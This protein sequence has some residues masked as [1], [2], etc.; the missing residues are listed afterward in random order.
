MLMQFKA[1]PLAM[2]QKTWQREIYGKGANSLSEA[3]FKGKGDFRGMAHLLAMSTVFG[4]LAMT[5]KGYL[6]GREARDPTD[7][8]TW[9]AAFLQ[10]GGAGLYGDFLFG[11]ATRHGQSAW[12]SFL[13]PTGGSIES[14]VDLYRRAL[15]GDDT[16]SQGLRFI[17]NHT[18]FANLFWARPALDYLF[19]YD[20]QE[21]LN[22]GA[23]RRM[24][25]FTK[26]NNEQEFWLKPS[27]DRLRP[28]TG[29]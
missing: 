28:F 19:L 7:P 5:A 10:G 3:L 11:Q 16:A 21:A 27:Q 26:K 2:M 29:I 12:G 9:L 20:L 14:L 18:P 23:L 25:A 13:G 4:Y 6:K 15:N 22:P 8:S 1:F 17:I 24:E